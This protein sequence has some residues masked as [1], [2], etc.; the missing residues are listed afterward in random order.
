ML[1]YNRKV[2][3]HNDKW[4]NEFKGHPEP[5]YHVYTLGQ[6]GQVIATPNSGEYGTYVTLSNTPSLGYE[7]VNY[8]IT[9]APWYNRE[10]FYIQHNDAYV[11]GNFNAIVRTVACSGDN[12]T[13]VATPNTGI[14]GDTITLSNTP[15]AGY[16]F[17]SYSISGATLYDTNKFDIYISDVNVVGAFISYN[18]LNLPAN[19]IRVR[20]NDGNAPIKGYASSYQ[21][22][23]LVDGTTDIYD[24]YKSGTSFYCLLQ[25][26][27]N[28][29]AVLGG[30]TTNITNMESM[31]SGADKLTSVAL[32]DTSN[33]TNMTRMFHACKTL[34]AIPLFDTSSV[35]NMHGMFETCE[36][37]TSIPLF[38]TSNVID[39]AFMFGHCLALTTVPL[40]DTSNVTDM[41]AMFHYCESLINIPLFD[42]SKVTNMS[43]MFNRCISIKS[44]PL[45]NTSKVTNMNYMFALCYKVESGALAL[46]NQASTQTTPPTS[47]TQTFYNCGRDTTTGAAEVAQIPSDWK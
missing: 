43:S 20:T 26:A 5:V 8:S 1:T 46:Y 37:I 45:F 17:D 35:T 22:A 12:G 13:V 41:Q 3:T 6:G 38:N 27:T 4:F 42:T 47:H 25:G 23:T 40:F 24:V 36:L 2:I 30:N 39:M 33:V 15:D 7:F 14:I 34:P 21:T 9:G 31:F 11:E 29:V 10:S 16:Y 19:T 44:I 28:V 18:P 32:F